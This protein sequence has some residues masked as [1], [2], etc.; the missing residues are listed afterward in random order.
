MDYVEWRKSAPPFAEWVRCFLEGSTAIS[1]SRIPTDDLR[2]RV[3]SHFLPTLGIQP[4]LGR[5]FT[6]ED[7][8]PHAPRVALLSY[9]VWR[10]RYG[11]DP[12]IVGRSISLDGEPVQI[13]GVLPAEFEMPTLTRADL[14]IPAVLD[15]A[16]MRRDNQLV[17]RTF[18]G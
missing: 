14:L 1:P 16:D 12:K 10:S 4:F 13:I 17:L 7:C 15:E 11:G 3:D 5:N 6:A 2:S 8:R 18:G 9:G